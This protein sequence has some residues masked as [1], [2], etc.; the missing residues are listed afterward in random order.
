MLIKYKQ[1]ATTE[2][3]IVKQDKKT[4][5]L[6]GFFPNDDVSSDKLIASADSNG[7]TEASKDYMQKDCE[8]VNYSSPQIKD[9]I[10]YL[11]SQ[12]KIKCK[13]ILE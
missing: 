6:V 3:V 12:Y 4:K 10:K 5:G 11:E 7:F 2:D 9:F 1:A 8:S 13:L